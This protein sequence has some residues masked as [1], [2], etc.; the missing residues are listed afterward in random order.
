[1]QRLDKET[2]SQLLE[3]VARGNLP[4]TKQKSIVVLYRPRCPFAFAAHKAR[5]ADNRECMV[6]I[7]TG[8]PFT[9]AKMHQVMRRAA[10]AALEILE[11]RT[12]AV[13]V[14]E[15]DA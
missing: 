5:S 4:K 3:L 12:S 6:R 14:R 13:E 7:V 8:L 10:M 1:M 15:E 9:H 2:N 11:G